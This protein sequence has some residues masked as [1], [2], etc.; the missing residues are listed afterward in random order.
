LNVI[1]KPLFI[2]GID[3][4]VQNRLGEEVYGTYFSLFSFCYLFQ[5]L[6][7][8][9]LQN[10]NITSVSKEPELFKT[11]FFQIIASK[12]MLAVV[13]A[14][15]IFLGAYLLGYDQD[16]MSLLGAIILLQIAISFGLFIRTN[17]S[18][19]GNYQKDSILS[20]VDKLFLI[21]VIGG[22]LYLWSN[23]IDFTIYTWVYAQL[24]AAICVIFFS[25]IS[26]RKHLSNIR[27]DD[28]LSN[29]KS[30]L[31]KSYPFALVFLLMTLY[32]KM[33]AVMLERM[34]QDGGKEAGI[35]AAA[36][37]L[38]EAGNMFA[39]L[40][41]SLLLPMFAAKLDNKQEIYNISQA[42]LRLLLPFA[43]IAV[44]IS[45]FYNVELMTQI[46]T[47]G[48]AYYGQVLQLLMLGFFCMSMSYIYGTLITA[49]QKLFWFNIAF[50]IG[51][52]INWSL[53]YYLIP[54]YMA[55]GAAIATIATQ[56]FILMAQFILAHKLTSIKVNVPLIFKTIVFV[57]FSVVV[58][59][60]L[61]DMFGFNHWIYP[62][63]LSAIFSL[64]ISFL[65]GLLRLDFASLF[66]EQRKRKNENQ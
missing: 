1:V 8:P 48:D 59:R 52:L 26:L 25:L 41:A 42:A 23:R 11:Q 5:V 6:I 65:V 35:Y 10:Y 21:C 58:F 17:L 29:T 62:L 14:A 4:Q 64:L 57:G 40:F 37:R 60:F 18:A 7:D 22:I 61:P 31:K 50:V 34:L 45:Y 55:K 12:L 28:M 13:F 53:N 27:F 51:I 38:Y 54:E 39:F 36:F 33:D 44:L 32:T 19:L 9:G 63:A 47:Q 66:V 43:A 15:F 49:T 16:K 2:F 56:G 30:L 46:Y 24:L 3:A 20:V